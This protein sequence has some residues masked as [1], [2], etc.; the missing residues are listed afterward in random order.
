MVICPASFCIS[1]TL[2]LFKLC[3][4]SPQT[5]PETIKIGE[6]EVIIASTNQSERK[7]ASA[8]SNNKAGSLRSKSSSPHRTH[9]ALPNSPASRFGASPPTIQRP[10]KSFSPTVG[11]SRTKSPRRP[12]T[13]AGPRDTSN[14]PF[15]SEFELKERT[16][17]LTDRIFLSA[18]PLPK[19]IRPTRLVLR[20][21][22]TTAKTGTVIHHDGSDHLIFQPISL[23]HVRDW[24]EELARIE[25][26][27][28]RRSAD[29]LG[30]GKR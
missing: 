10:S 25:L 2:S 16:V 13:S 7:L 5:G 27:S 11:R 17:D 1:L 9:S 21:S 14:L 12:H 19:K 18:G 3:V 29:M 30:F 28:R 8:K 26:R 22:H 20:D 23:D 6:R 4:F 15:P 24:E